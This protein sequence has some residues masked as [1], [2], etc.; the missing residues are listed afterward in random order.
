[1]RGIGDR[2]VATPSPIPQRQIN[3]PLR[4]SVSAV[5]QCF[6][7][8]WDASPYARYY[9]ICERLAGLGWGNSFRPLSKTSYYQTWVLAGQTWEVQVRSAISDTEFSA[10]TDAKSAVANPR[11]PSPPQHVH[12]LPTADGIQVSWEPPAN[13]NRAFDRYEVILF[14]PDQPGEFLNSYSTR[15]AIHTFTG[16]RQN[17]SPT[18]AVVTWDR[19]PNV[20]GYRVWVWNV[21]WG[22][23]FN[24]T[25]EDTTTELHYGFGFLFP[26][27]WN[28]EFCV[29]AYNGNLESAR[30]LC[31]R[32]EKWP[33][34]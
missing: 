7:A 12:R 25:S 17:Q 24:I 14:D 19:V 30:S 18:D 23:E 20:A 28:F 21:E 8:K 31:V 33:G 5:P 11:T 32:P 34:F 22:H 2:A 3:Q 27:T 16:L 6:M 13:M 9:Q 15:S 1:M 4:F 10:W 26:G 29:S